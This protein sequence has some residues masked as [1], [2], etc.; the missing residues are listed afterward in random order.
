MKMRLAFFQLKYLHLN[1]CFFAGTIRR[2]C[3]DCRRPGFDTFYSP[4]FTDFCDFFIGA[5]PDQFLVRRALIGHS[6][7]KGYFVPFMYVFGTVYGNG[8]YTLSDYNS[9]FFLNR[10]FYLRADR[11]HCRSFSDCFYVSLLRYLSHFFVAAF[12][13]QGFY[14]GI[15]RTDLRLQGAFLPLFHDISVC[16]RIGDL[17]F[18]DVFSYPD[19][20]SFCNL[21][22]L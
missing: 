7:L 13:K 2:R 20:H 14:C 12:K 21:F 10:G 6:R 11:D 16:R 3:R 5:L 19:G 1:R 9:D 15:L 17:D 22:V 18:F 8:F 4:V